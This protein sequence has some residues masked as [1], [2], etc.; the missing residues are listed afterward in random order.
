MYPIPLESGVVQ[1]PVVLMPAETFGET[2]NV[3]IGL[4]LPVDLTLNYYG[5]AK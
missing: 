3:H 4:Y 1:I 5:Y 2:L